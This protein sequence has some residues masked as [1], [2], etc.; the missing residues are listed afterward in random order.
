MLHKL[1]RASV[2]PSGILGRHDQK[3]VTSYI[4][5][6]N[7]SASEQDMRF[8]ICQQPVLRNKLEHQLHSNLKL[9]I[10]QT[11][12]HPILYKRFAAKTIQSA[13]SKI[14]VT[15]H[16]PHSST[17]PNGVDGLGQHH[18]CI[19]LGGLDCYAEWDRRCDWHYGPHDHQRTL[20]PQCYGW[21]EGSK[22]VP[23]WLK[24][25]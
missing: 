21:Q 5:K 13:A 1:L 19:C 3:G 24:R 22:E 8:I 20:L 18:V 2:E 16:S 9:S 15:D 25:N 14:I 23:G 11:H 12:G 10:I 17:C 7:T 4:P 6:M